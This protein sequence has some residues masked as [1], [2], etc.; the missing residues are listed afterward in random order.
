[1]YQNF[2]YDHY[3]VGKVIVALHKDFANQIAIR[4]IRS[5]LDELNYEKAEVIFHLERSENKS[6]VGDILLIYLNNN[7]TLAVVHAL[8]KL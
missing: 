4:D 1:M 6:D 5:V 8:E 3:E 7:D 2:Y